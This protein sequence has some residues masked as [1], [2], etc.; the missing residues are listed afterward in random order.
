MLCFSFFIVRYQIPESW[1]FEEARQLFKE[2]LV[3]IEEDKLN[4]K[5]NPPDEEVVLN[6]RNTTST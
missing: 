6:L 1:P 5:W 3:T 4:L 2:P